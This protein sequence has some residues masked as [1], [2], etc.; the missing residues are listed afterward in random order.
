MVRRRPVKPTI[1]GSTPSTGALLAYTEGQADWRRQPLRKRS[2][3]KSALT[4][5]TPSPSAE[6]QVL[7]AERQRLQASNLARRVRFPQSTL[8]SAPRR[9]SERAKEIRV[10]STPPDDAG[11]QE[12]YA[13]AILRKRRYATR[14]RGPTATTLG[15]H[16]GKD[17]SI[18]SGTT[19]DVQTR[20]SL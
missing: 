8:S 4:G 6:H 11:N 1:E 3:A 19:H 12:P 20:E 7:L 14:S 16:P 9:L 10:G 5:S 13:N 15:S 17:G 18:P 2:S